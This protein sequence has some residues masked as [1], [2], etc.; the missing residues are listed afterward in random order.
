MEASWTVL[1]DGQE[2]YM[3]YV[4]KILKEI[5]EADNKVSLSLFQSYIIFMH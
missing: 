2:L 4:E 5:R 3:L 1:Q